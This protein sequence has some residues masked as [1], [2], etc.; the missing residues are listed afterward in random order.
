MNRTRIFA[1][2][3]L[4]ILSLFLSQT[5]TP[6]PIFIEF[7]RCEGPSTKCCFAACQYHQHVSSCSVVD[8]NLARLFS[9]GP[10]LL[11]LHASQAGQWSSPVDGYRR[12]RL[13][14]PPTIHT[15]TTFRRIGETTQIQTTKTTTHD[16]GE[17]VDCHC[18]FGLGD[19]RI[20]F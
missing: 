13:D 4:L 9:F 2:V 12:I 7:D 3:D 11:F 10:P 18:V 14:P 8:S 16:T 19:C 5:Q 15:T 6:T 20:Q 17:K 1:L